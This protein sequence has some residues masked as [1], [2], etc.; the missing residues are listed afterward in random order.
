MSTK[1]I[2]N[3]DQLREMG[4]RSLDCVLEQ[5]DAGNAEEAKRLAQRMYNEF[6]AMHDLYR[7]WITGTLSSVGK[8]YGD[9]ALEEVMTEGL[10]SWWTPMAEKINAVPDDFTRKVKMFVAGLRGHLQ[11]MDIREDDEKIEIRMMHFCSGGRQIQACKYEGPNAFLKVATPQRMTYGRPDVPVYC[12]HEIA[13]ERLDAIRDGHPFVITEPAA[14]LGRDYCVLKI[15][16]D[17][18]DIPAHY[19]ERLGLTKP[20][21][22]A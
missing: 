12:T 17:P 9:V 20:A 10:D 2:F 6:V 7:D 3:D 14:K 19:Y 11:P 5:I 22:D 8:R 1:R 4:R 18:K 13:M 15:Y 16:K 21:G